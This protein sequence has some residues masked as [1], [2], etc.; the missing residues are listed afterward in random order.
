MSGIIIQDTDSG[1][2]RH[3][4]G[5]ISR[6]C[7][8]ALYRA[9]WVWLEKNL[10]WRAPECCIEEC[11]R[12]ASK[13]SQV[14]SRRQILSSHLWIKFNGCNHE[15]HGFFFK[16]NFYLFTLIFLK[17]KYSSFTISY[18]NIYFFRNF[19]W[20]GAPAAYGSSQVRGP[21]GAAANGLYHSNEEFE[22]HLWPAPQLLASLD[23]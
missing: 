2:W 18:L 4:S 10:E 11:G 23:P 1:R 21:I 16:L 3:M 14:P 15:I 17:L 6:S 19:F 7:M 13:P 22:P 9:W 20:R 8:A 5:T 12:Q